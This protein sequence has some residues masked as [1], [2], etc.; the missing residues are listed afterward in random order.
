M[1]SL[2]AV[3]P[4]S[5]PLVRSGDVPTPPAPGRPAEAARETPREHYLSRPSGQS[6]FEVRVNVGGPPRR[7]SPA[8]SRRK[9]ARMT[10]EEA[11]KVTP[12]LNA[13]M[14]TAAVIPVLRG[15]AAFDDT[16]RLLRHNVSRLRQ[17]LDLQGA[18]E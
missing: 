1:G 7:S 14:A 17:I 8:R 2:V 9:A 12:L 5:P 10:I 15:K 4:S 11:K 3:D 13:I 6:R 16:T 18:A